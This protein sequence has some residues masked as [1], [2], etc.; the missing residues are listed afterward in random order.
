M[1]TKFIGLSGIGS[2]E[3]LWIIRIM[4][5]NLTVLGNWSYRLRDDQGELWF[6]VLATTYGLV[7][8]KLI[9]SGGNKVSG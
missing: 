4:K 5:F 2:M 6:K 9:R 7:G 8:I 3:G 1:L